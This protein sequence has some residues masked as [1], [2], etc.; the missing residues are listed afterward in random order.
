[1]RI[2]R[3][4][5]YHSSP[6]RYGNAS[7]DHPAEARE[8]SQ[9]AVQR[10]VGWAFVPPEG[11]RCKSVWKRGLTQSDA[12]EFSGFVSQTPPASCGPLGILLS[13]PD[14]ARPAAVPGLTEQSG[15]AKTISALPEFHTAPLRIYE[16]CR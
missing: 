11:A 12:G 2:S 1:M 13:S 4:N 14:R 9:N 7:A 15:K 8:P 10:G 6:W 3:T 16:P 5:D